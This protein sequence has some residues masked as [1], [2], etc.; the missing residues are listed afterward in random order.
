[1]AHRVL[2]ADAEAENELSESV[3]DDPVVVR[4]RRVGRQQDD[5]DQDD[6]LRS[7]GGLQTPDE[8]CCRTAQDNNCCTNTL[9]AGA[10]RLAAPVQACRLGAIA[11]YPAASLVHGRLLL[12]TI[13]I[14]TAPCR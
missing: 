13:G 14:D 6:R 12:V 10:S 8:A 11:V 3:E 5:A 1:M 2:A 9:T 4:A 7:E